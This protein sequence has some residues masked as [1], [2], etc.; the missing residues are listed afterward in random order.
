[1]PDHGMIPQHPLPVGEFMRRALHDPRHGY[2]ARRITGVGRGGDFTTAPML[3][4]SLARAVAG[5]VAA[6]LRET[7]CRDLIEIGPGEGV[8]AEE[9]WKRLP[10]KLRWRARLHLVET[11]APL[12][13]IQR[14]RLGRRARWHG[15][16]AE[17]LA[18]CGGRAVVFSNELVDAFPARVFEK[19]DDGWREVA[20]KKDSEG[21]VTECLLDAAELPQS[22]SFGID[23]P[24]GQRVEV[25]DSYH[26]WLEAWLPLWRAGRMLT[27]DYGNTAEKIYHRRPRGTLRGYLMQQ[28]LT[29]MEIY[30]NPGRQD[31]TV[32]VNFTDLIE[33]SRPW[34][35]DERVATLGKF[36]GET[37][38]LTEPGGPGEAFLV[39]DQKCR[40]RDA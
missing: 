35:C 15:H 38:I 5:W 21:R 28:R 37:G 11:S 32:D 18:E 23:H 6:A 4:G 24:T 16:P 17:A 22:S 9:V 33:W 27:I 25:H 3:D 10:W 36:T 26:K 20:V 39:L 19:T 14:R 30:Q 13:E 8:L 34:T 40:A 1:M 7:G 29:G 12:R 2:Y 31:L